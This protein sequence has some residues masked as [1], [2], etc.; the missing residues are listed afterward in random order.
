MF[1]CAGSLRITINGT[2]DVRQSNVA[3]DNTNFLSVLWEVFFCVCVLLLLHLRSSAC[4]F[5]AG[6]GGGMAIESRYIRVASDDST[7]V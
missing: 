6:Q 2:D 1:G 7:F 5:G 4:D 3:T